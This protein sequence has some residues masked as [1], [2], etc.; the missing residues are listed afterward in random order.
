MLYS[1]RMKSW[2]F[3]ESKLKQ[4]QIK[5]TEHIRHM[6]RFFGEDNGLIFKLKKSKFSFASSIYPL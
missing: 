4:Y 6:E 5:K 2:V 3:K 1:E